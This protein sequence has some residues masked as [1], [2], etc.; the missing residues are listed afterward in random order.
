[1]S[2]TTP[3]WIH[4]VNVCDFAIYSDVRFRLLSLWMFRFWWDHRLPCGII[5]NTNKTNEKGPF[6]AWFQSETIIYIT[7]RWWC[8]TTLVLIPSY[9]TTHQPVSLLHQ[10]R[11]LIVRTSDAAERKW[12]PNQFKQKSNQQREHVRVSLAHHNLVNVSFQ[13]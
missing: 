13:F 3:A 12:F 9:E 11:Q 5:N 7:T 10:W 6:S 1:M 2:L 8:L 4:I